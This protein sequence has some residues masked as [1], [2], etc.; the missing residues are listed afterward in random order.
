MPSPSPFKVL[1]AEGS[2][3]DAVRVLEGFAEVRL[4]PPKGRYTEADLIRELA[5]CDAV[6]ISSRT[7]VSRQVIASCPRLKV[8]SKF[9]A[10]PDN[11]DF[12]AASERG[13]RVLWTPLSN[14][15]SVAEFA[16][17]LMLSLL[18][19]LSQA[20]EVLRQGKWR[21]DTVHTSDIRG[22]TVG[23][24]GLGNVGLRVCERLRGFQ[25]KLIAHDPF[26]TP[27]RAEQAGV[28][29]VDFQTLLGES[30]VVSL[31]AT[32][33]PETRHLFGYAQFQA[34]KRGAILVNTARGGLVDETALGRALK[35]GLIAGAGL[36]VFENEPP[37]PDNP[38]LSMDNVIATP[39]I[40]ARTHDT[41]YRERAWAAE[42][43]KRVLQGQE[44]IHC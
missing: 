16:V 1:I 36:D 44:P 34:M 32:L 18:R 30:D 28:R 7:G 4:A 42:D 39:H 2:S 31:H 21:N 35:E 38:L 43:V 27:G 5:G 22:R 26:V 13:I 11:V 17:L 25:P 20:V 37:A 24:V 9:G 23:L 14:P 33:T 19:K 15:D 6:I 29:L 12:Q 8:I 10:K 40:A 3:E 41:V